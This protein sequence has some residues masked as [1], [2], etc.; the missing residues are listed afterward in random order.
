MEKNDD[1]AENDELSDDEMEFDHIFMKEFKEKRIQG[2]RIL[3]YYAP[4]L[5]LAPLYLAVLLLMM[6]PLFNKK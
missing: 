4:S 2:N 1:F 6:A 3:P 5:V